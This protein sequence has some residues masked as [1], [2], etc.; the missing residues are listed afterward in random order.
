MAKLGL[1]ARLCWL[2]KESNPR[3]LIIPDFMGERDWSASSW[4]LSPHFSRLVGARR[5]GERWPRHQSVLPNAERPAAAAAAAAERFALRCPRPSGG[6]ETKVEHA[7]ARPSDWGPARGCA[8]PAVG[9]PT[10]GQAPDLTALILSDTCAH[11][12]AVTDSRWAAVGHDCGRARHSAKS[13][14]VWRIGHQV[15]GERR[16][17]SYSRFPRGQQQQQQTNL[18]SPLTQ[19]P[20]AIQAELVANPNIRLSTLPTGFTGARAS[21]RAQTTDGLA[22]ASKATTLA[23]CLLR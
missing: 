5:M 13:A 14:G 7:S 21:P 18:D 16:A 15:R 9:A 12:P 8:T 3:S 11:L 17:Q 1:L 22:A 20:L 19:I 4:P 6:A 2:R 10:G 23:Y